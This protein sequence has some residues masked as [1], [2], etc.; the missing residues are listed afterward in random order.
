M[1][2]VSR[3]SVVV[4]R[5]WAYRL[6][7]TF[8]VFQTESLN[9][10]GVLLVKIPESAAKQNYAALG[11]DAGAIGQKN[12]RGFADAP[13]QIRGLALPTVD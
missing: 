1:A 11:V 5:Q 2:V 6:L 7:P 3:Q 8:F 4:S 10:F 12:N 13:M 9:S